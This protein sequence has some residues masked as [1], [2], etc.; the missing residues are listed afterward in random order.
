LKDKNENEN[1]N[2]FGNNKFIDDRT[3]CGLG[4]EL[5]ILMDVFIPKLSKDEKVLKEIKKGFYEV[6]YFIGLFE[7]F[8]KHV[9]EKE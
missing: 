7:I 2:K 4:S 5:D 3:D 1:K 6:K 9:L 8:I